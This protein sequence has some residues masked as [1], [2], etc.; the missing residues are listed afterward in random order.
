MHTGGEPLRIITSGYPEIIGD[1]IL[2][3]R[4]YVR[5][6]LD[7]LRRLLM[8]EPRG[9]YDQYGALLVKPD[10]PE[11]DIAVIFMHNEGYSTMCGHAVIALGRFA[12]DYGYKKI[13]V[14]SKHQPSHSVNIQCP[15]GLVRTEVKMQ[16]RKP[17]T[18]KFLS[19][20]SFAF[21]TDI[22]I[23][24]CK[25]GPLTLDI[26][27]GGA[28]YALVSQDKLGVDVETSPVRDLVDAADAISTCVKEQVKILH[29]EEEDLSF[30]YGTIITDG[31]DNFSDEP[32]SNL[33]V[34]ADRQ[35]DRCPTGSGV[36]ARIAVQFAKNLIPLRAE[37]TFKN[38]PVKSTF[39]GQAFEETTCGE[40]K[41]VRVQVCGVAFY[42]GKCSFTFEEDD[43]LRD[44]FLVK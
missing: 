36:T 18:V 2:E 37:R 11:A 39:T 17:M 22:T 34:F 38:G 14:D 28:F 23:N 12:I 26:G 32:T 33:C 19:V 42:T 7:H 31:K 10:H 41:A 29:P 8:F 16:N 43:P 5:E 30:L 6:H 35:V 13:P 24:T 4:R 27:Y 40:L 3:K 15:C 20:P 25:Y 1:T 21:A 9:H 44:G